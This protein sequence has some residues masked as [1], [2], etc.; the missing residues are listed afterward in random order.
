M[1]AF[2]DWYNREDAHEHDYSAN[3]KDWFYDCWQAACEH[4]RDEVRALELRS[5]GW[6]AQAGKLTRENEDLEQK[7]RELEQEN[8][9]LRHTLSAQPDKL[10]STG[11]AQ[12]QMEYEIDIRDRRIKDLEQ[13]L[14]F[15][16]QDRLN[17]KCVIQ[18]LE[19][20]N[21]RLDGWRT[22][23]QSDVE[24]LSEDCDRLRRELDEANGVIR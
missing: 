18:E 9:M 17:L 13:R 5:Q 20:E 12:A 22:G 1:T 10:T 21:E 24:K 15:S 11:A 23:L 8:K 7:C 3:P 16:D 6:A 2:D 4:Q 19:Q 14:Y